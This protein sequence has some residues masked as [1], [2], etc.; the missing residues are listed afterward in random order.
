MHMKLIALRRYCG[1]HGV[2]EPGR[3]FE[4]PEPLVRNLIT[5]RIAIQAPVD[6]SSDII[7]TPFLAREVTAA[8]PPAAV[9]RELH[10]ANAAEARDGHAEYHVV[11]GAGNELSDRTDNPSR[12]KRRRGRPRRK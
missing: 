2:V 11:S 8:A 12:E 5:H 4:C 6:D 7:E 10:H 9:F 1:P 3:T